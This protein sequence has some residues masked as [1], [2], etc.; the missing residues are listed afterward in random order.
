MTI[1]AVRLAPK[2]ISSWIV[3]ID[4]RKAR[5]FERRDGIR[6]LAISG[7]SKQRTLAEKVFP[8]LTLLPERCLEA[9]ST[10][11]YQIGKDASTR[12]Q[13]EAAIGMRLE[14]LKHHLLRRMAEQLHTAWRQRAF[15]ELVIIAPPPMLTKFKSLL[16]PSVRRRISAELQK[17]LAS[18]D[19]QTIMTHI[20]HLLPDTGVHHAAVS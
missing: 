13:T 17:N 1:N 18:C 7:G 8:T 11:I 4:G 3:V 10:E 2:S 6:I 9:E 16:D 19:G 5:I 20:R 12:H 14:E 15:N